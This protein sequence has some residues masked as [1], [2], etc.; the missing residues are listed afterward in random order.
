[1][2]AAV[3]KRLLIILTA[4]WLPVLL[5]WWW[6]HASADSQNPFFPPLQQIW[7]QFQ[8]N[9]VFN[10]VGEDVYPSLRNLFLGLLLGSAIGLIGGAYLGASRRVAKFVEPVIDFLRAIPPVATVPV[11]I[12]IFGLDMSM[13][14]AAI[15]FAS[16]FPVMLATIQGVRSTDPT[17]MDTAKVFHLS[18][19]QVLWRV[20]MPAAAP[21]IFAGLQIALQVA[22]VVTIASEILGAGFGIGAFTLIATQS[23]MILDAWTGVILLGLLGYAL[24]LAFDGLERWVLRWYYGQKKIAG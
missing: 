22:F 2:I 7:D 10:L 8:V 5:V 6:W 21:T 12:L 11:F 13:R 23:F 14:V 18:P 19:N 1:M 17:L 24:N 9:W 4:A 3:G 16:L 20:R 15:T